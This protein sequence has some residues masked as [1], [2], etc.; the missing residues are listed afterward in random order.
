MFTEPGK[1][2]VVIGIIAVASGILLIT[3]QK[4]GVPVF[5]RWFGNLPLDFKIVRDNFKLYFPL[6]TSIV[7][8][9]ILSFLLY[10]FNKIIR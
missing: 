4:T 6:G 7:L 9:V 1:L 5:M 10:L 3:L 2:L 8:S